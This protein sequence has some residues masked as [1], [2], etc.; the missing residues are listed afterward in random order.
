MKFEE[1]GHGS[2]DQYG[3]LGLAFLV[4]DSLPVCSWF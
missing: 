1:Q 2:L 3:G 4:S